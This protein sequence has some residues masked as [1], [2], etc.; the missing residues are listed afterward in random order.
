MT[1]RMAFVRCSE[2]IDYHVRGVDHGQAPRALREA[3]AVSSKNKQKKTA[4]P[5]PL[6]PALE[7]H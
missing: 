3:V 7:G 5:I 1:K 4:Y 2:R 6:R